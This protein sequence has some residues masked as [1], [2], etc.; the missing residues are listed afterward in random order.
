M[1]SPTLTAYILVF[2]LIIY[3]IQDGRA[4]M[5]CV[6][7]LFNT[8]KTRIKIF[9][10]VLPSWD[11]NQTWLVFTIAGL[12]GGFP[13]FFGQFMSQHY[14]FFFILLLL[15][16]LR[17]ASIEFYIKSTKFK[18]CWL[19][20]LS[21]SSLLILA[22]HIF[23]CALLIDHA[24]SSILALFVIAAFVLWFNSTQAYCFLFCLH[25][26]SQLGHVLV[27]FLNSTILMNVLNI[28]VWQSHLTSLI[29]LFGLAYLTSFIMLTML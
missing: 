18:Y 13:I 5:L 3:L 1:T 11:A 10:D 20:L 9:N 16:I 26:S 25:H 21:I 24:H 17:G 2:T 15:L 6:F 23:L 14:S 28:S 29:Y 7:A 8:K 27:L 12:Y 4:L 22:C 19:L